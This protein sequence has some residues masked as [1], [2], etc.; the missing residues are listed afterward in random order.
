MY[1]VIIVWREKPPD[2]SGGQLNL[3]TLSAATLDPVA[4][5][6]LQKVKQLPPWLRF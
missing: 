1:L 2:I 5:L 6:Q 4:V 3:L